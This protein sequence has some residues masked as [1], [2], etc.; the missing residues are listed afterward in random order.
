MT[1]QPV[2]HSPLDPEDILRRL[3]REE[4][5]R[6]IRDYRSALEAAH[7]LWR[8]RQLQDVLRLWDLRATA[9][10]QPDFAARAQ[11]A[12]ASDPTDFVPAEQAIP[13]W[14]DRPGEAR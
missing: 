9:Y 11:S 10:A 14:S 13:G 2:E 5:D 12:Q 4:R 1:A 8:Y 6:F 3:P 7:E